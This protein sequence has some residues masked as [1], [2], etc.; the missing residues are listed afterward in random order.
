VQINPQACVQ[1]LGARPVHCAI[2]L[3]E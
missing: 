3:D 2:S 1:A